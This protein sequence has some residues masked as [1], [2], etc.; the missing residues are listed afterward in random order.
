MLAK[1]IALKA[2]GG[3]SAKA[4]ADYIAGEREQQDAPE[5]H[6]SDPTAVADYVNREGVSEGASFNLEGLDPADP[7]DRAL[8]VAQMDHVARAGQHKTG[9]KSNPFYHFVL[10]WREGSWL[11]SA[12]DG[13]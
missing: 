6:S 7:Q 1:V 5:L 10:S 3:F 13:A 11:G 4:V 2:K 12:S 9:F 8:I